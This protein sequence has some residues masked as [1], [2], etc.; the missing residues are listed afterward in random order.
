MRDQFQH[1]YGIKFYTFDIVHALYWNKV[2]PR[3]QL[4]RENYSKDSIVTQLLDMGDNISSAYIGFSPAK[5][6]SDI[7]NLVKRFPEQYSEWALKTTDEISSLTNME[8]S[9]IEKK[10][11]LYWAYDLHEYIQK[12]S[13]TVVIFIDS[14]EALWRKDKSL[15]KGSLRNNLSNT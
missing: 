3:V 6:V 13:K 10:L 12:T 4:N 9:D 15:A 1:N 8:P 14:Y 7:G 2:N 5:L 11:Y